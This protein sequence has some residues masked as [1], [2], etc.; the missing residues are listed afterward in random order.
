MFE[1]LK[2]FPEQGSSS[3][4]R[5]RPPDPSSR[6]SVDHLPSSACVMSSAVSISLL[7]LL[8]A[9]FQRFPLTE[10]GH[11]LHRESADL[12]K[13]LT[14]W[15][16]S[17]ACC[18]G[19]RQAGWVDHEMGPDELMEQTEAVWHTLNAVCRWTIQSPT[20]PMKEASEVR[21]LRDPVL[22][23]SGNPPFATSS[24]TSSAR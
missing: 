7:Q 13:Q 21:M 4:A 16:S 10:G 24:A 15:L 19:L 11:F 6:E 12:L 23:D 1:G 2:L 14:K 3:D 22:G 20:A 9:Y 18:K 17:E 5:A 8:A